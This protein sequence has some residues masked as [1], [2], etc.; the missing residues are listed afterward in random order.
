MLFFYNVSNQT[1]N[2][3][4][5]DFIQKQYDVLVGEGKG[6]GNAYTAVLSSY[7]KHH[8]AMMQSTDEVRNELKKMKKHFE[9]VDVYYVE[10]EEDIKKYLKTKGMLWSVICMCCIVIFGITGALTVFAHNQQPIISESTALPICIVCGICFYIAFGKGNKYRKQMIIMKDLWPS[11]IRNSGVDYHT[12][13]C[14]LKIITW[15]VYCILNS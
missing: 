11:N 6:G 4:K 1:Q 15:Y 14:R 5:H 2:N 10:C 3:M 12:F 8:L 9:Q 13:F 7:S